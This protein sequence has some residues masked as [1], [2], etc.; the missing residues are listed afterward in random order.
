[1]LVGLFAETFGLVDASCAEYLADT[2]S[3]SCSDFKHCDVVAKLKDAYPIGN[4]Y[5]GSSEKEMM[6]E[7]RKNGPI[8]ADFEPPLTFQFYKHGIFSDNHSDLLKHLKHAQVSDIKNSDLN[9]MTLSD[10]NI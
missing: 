5:G 9:E 7:I 1:M 4:F 10:Y 8:V 2:D 3:Q 6:L